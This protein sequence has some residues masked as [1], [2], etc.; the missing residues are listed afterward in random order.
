MKIPELDVPLYITIGMFVLI[1]L[2]YSCAV[3]SKI[4]KNERGKMK[5]QTEVEMEVEIKLTETQK[6]II[7]AVKEERERC[8]ADLCYLCKGGAPVVRMDGPAGSW[9][10]PGEMSYRMCAGSAIR[11]RAHREAV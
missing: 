2:L 5:N 3:E 6:A 4:S 10:H 1:A 8:I 11:E 9:V 7:G